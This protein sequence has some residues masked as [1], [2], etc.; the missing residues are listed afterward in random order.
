MADV[1]EVVTEDANA[2]NAEHRDESNA[3][4]ATEVARI[5]GKIDLFARDRAIGWVVDLMHPSAPLTL[6]LLKGNQVLAEAAANVERTDLAP[7]FGPDINHGFVLQIDHLQISEPTEISF[8]VKEAGVELKLPANWNRIHIVLDEVAEDRILGWAYDSFN[9]NQHIQLRFSQGTEEIGTTIAD[10][11]RSDLTLAGIGGGDHA[12]DFQAPAGTVIQKELLL[13]DV[14]PHC[15]PTTN[16]T[17]AEQRGVPAEPRGGRGTNWKALAERFFDD[18]WYCSLLSASVPHK[19]SF[20][21]WWDHG[22]HKNLSPH[23]LFD[24]IFYAQQLE[25]PISPKDYFLHYLSSGHTLYVDPHPCFSAR[26][27]QSQYTVRDHDH[28]WLDYVQYG[29]DKGRQ[30]NWLFSYSRPK[31]TAQKLPHETNLGYYLMHERQLGLS[32]HALLDLP[33]VVQHNQDVDAEAPYIPFW[34][35]YRTREIRTHIYFDPNF[36]LRQIKQRSTSL[37]ALADY[38]LFGERANLKPIPLF[39]PAWYRALYE[40]GI[41]YTS[42]LEEYTSVGE[43]LFRHPCP[44]FDPRFYLETHADVARA[45]VPP[46]R[47]FMA[48]GQKE[49]REIHRRFDLRWYAASLPEDRRGSALEHWLEY[50]RS[51]GRSTHPALIVDPRGCASEAL[52]AFL[53]PNPKP[54]WLVPNLRLALAVRNEPREISPQLSGQAWLVDTFEREARAPATVSSSRLKC[55]ESICRMSQFFNYTRSESY[56]ADLDERFRL[57]GLNLP[58]VSVIIP[59]RNR[60]KVI[61]RAIQSVLTQTHRKFEILIIDDGSIDNTGALISDHFRDR[62]VRYIHQTGKGVSAARNEGLRNSCGDY[63]AYLDSDNYWEPTHLEVMLKALLLQRAVTGYS[64]LRIFNE[65]GDIRYRGDHFDMT[66]LRRENYV[67]MNVYVHHRSVIEQG[68]HF[69]ERL[70]RCVDWDFILRVSELHEPMYVPIVGCNY[71]DDNGSL[72]RITTN[73][74]SGDFF[75]ICRRGIDLASHITGDEPEK[76]CRATIIWAISREDWDISKVSVWDIANHLDNSDDELIIVNNALSA[77]ATRFLEVF[78]RMVPKARVV[79]LWRNFFDFPAANMV[80]HLARGEHLLLWRSNLVFDSAAIDELLEVAAASCAKVICPLVINPDGAVSSELAHATLDSYVLQPLMWGQYDLPRMGLISGIVPIHTPVV[81]SRN[82]F[83][84]ADGFRTM[85][86]GY[87]G[88]ADYCMSMLEVSPSST[89]LLFSVRIT[90]RGSLRPTLAEGEFLREVKALRE[91]W[92][93]RLKVIPQATGELSFKTAAIGKGM[94]I[95]WTLFPSTDSSSRVVMPHISRAL[96]FVIR[97]PSPEGEEQK[98]WGDY[99]YAK[100]MASALGELGYPAVLQHREEWGAAG[101]LGDVV[102]HIR[103]IVDVRPIPGLLNVMW[104][105]SHPDRINIDEYGAMDRVFVAGSQLRTTL[106]QRYGLDACLL[107]QGADQ[108]KFCDDI[109]AFPALSQK[110][111]FVGNS[112][113]QLRG[114]VSDAIEAQLPLVVYGRDWEHFIPPTFVGGT[115][116]SH[117]ELPRW[118]GSAGVVLNDHWPTMRE[119][120]IVSNR[121]FDVVATGRPVITDPVAGLDEIFMGAARSYSSSLDLV[122]MFDDLS[123]KSFP[124]QTKNIRAHHTIRSRMEELLQELGLRR[125]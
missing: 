69:D 115:F 85:F 31:D 27:Y 29:S 84:V 107:M 39:E 37:P 74:L 66:A 24:P 93:G 32:P 124:E 9:P 79:H 80:G 88:L 73:E 17:P 99:Y 112:R 23:P 98:W 25:K 6:Q 43:K 105:I 70:R 92:Q 48:S 82:D 125:R 96:R 106:G 57:S 101:T 16:D 78:S 7:Q 14:V 61:G 64:A 8:I 108:T 44:G 15:V 86:A 3:A 33:L 26:W 51:E 121:I 56:I 109:A 91:C 13:V 36:Y 122:E 81:I 90:T 118:Y 34:R 110:A 111:L 114:V 55:D 89:A 22:R 18:A 87:Y 60:A 83:L 10:R 54:D 100:A 30:P 77:S 113:L 4:D 95:D 58:F 63:I 72:E 50:G 19:R 116:I 102:F 97:T 104:V 53:V 65:K 1:T 76:A 2:S 40:A 120:G 52:E 5:K 46:L 11:A 12:F 67:D 75:A 47:H 41:G 45:G 119:Y 38:I 59:T 20:Q 49:L 68:F 117:E 35:A 94:N 103:G 42:Y 123:H 21:H 71:V 28:A 62:R